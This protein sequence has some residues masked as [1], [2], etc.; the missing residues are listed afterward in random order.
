MMACLTITV[1]VPANRANV[2]MTPDRDRLR[3]SSI[4]LLC[5]AVAVALGLVWLYAA[6]LQ[7]TVIARKWLALGSWL[8]VFVGECENSP[9][10]VAMPVA[11]HIWQ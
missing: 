6:I 10:L 2:L 11:I 3:R 9:L 7:G 1:D 5:L 4:T 8:N